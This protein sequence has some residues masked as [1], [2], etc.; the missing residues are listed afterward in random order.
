MNVAV[1][2][3][4]GEDGT[5]RLR[6]LRLH[7]RWQT[8]EQGRQWGDENGRH[9]LVMLAGGQVHEVVLNPATLT[10]SIPAS[11]PHLTPV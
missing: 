5:V 9:V 10:W 6:R 8:V 3:T 7:G 11:L 2:C 4:F 1:E